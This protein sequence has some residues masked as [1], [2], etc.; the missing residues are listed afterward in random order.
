[1]DE[2]YLQSYEQWTKEEHLAARGIYEQ[3]IDWYALEVADG[4]P[5]KMNDD[6]EGDDYT[7]S[8]VEGYGFRWSGWVK[9][10]NQMAWIGFTTLAGQLIGRNPLRS[11]KLTGVT[12]V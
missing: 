7:R 9:P 10:T 8:E 3:F 2:M 5:I 12:G 4:E 6:I 1:M 11:G